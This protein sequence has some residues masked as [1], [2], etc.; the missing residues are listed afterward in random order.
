M[1]DIL[2]YVKPELLIVALV[3]YF[4]GGALKTIPAIKDKYIPVILGIFGIVLCA[5][6]VF[7]RCTC[8][9]PREV[10]MAL[11]TSVTQ[12]LLVAG[13][14]TYVHQLLKQLQKKE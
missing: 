1:E 9:G 7:A 10:L 12:G 8:D 5:A 6:W 13:L 2:S 11:F 3:L 4:T 14:S